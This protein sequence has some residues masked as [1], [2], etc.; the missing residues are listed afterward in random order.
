MQLNYFKSNVRYKNL[1][2]L[3]GG[4]LGCMVD[5]IYIFLQITLNYHRHVSDNSF[6]DICPSYV[7]ANGLCEYIVEIRIASFQSITVK[8]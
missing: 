1:A 4:T 3:E 5:F 7:V 8:L 6:C 2:N